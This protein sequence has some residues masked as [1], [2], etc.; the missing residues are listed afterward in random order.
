MK[1]VQIY[2]YA[3]GFEDAEGNEFHRLDIRDA[4]EVDTVVQFMTIQLWHD[5]VIADSEILDA[6]TLSIRNAMTSAVQQFIYN[7]IMP[8]DD[9]E[10]AYKIFSNM[11]HFITLMARAFYDPQSIERSDLR[12]RK[13]LYHIISDGLK[14]RT[15]CTIMIF[16]TIRKTGDEYDLQTSY[17][18]MKSTSD[19]ALSGTLIEFK[20][21]EQ[22]PVTRNWRI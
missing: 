6:A 19:S 20:I 12:E 11:G 18:T 17:N 16:V 10:A 3:L 14:H 1:P 13:D 7:D 4:S 9:P 15:D 2:L 21:S 22:V 5:R 8:I